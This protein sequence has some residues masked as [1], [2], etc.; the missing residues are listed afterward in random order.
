MEKIGRR[1]IFTTKADVTQEFLDKHVFYLRT[2]YDVSRD[3]YAH[4]ETDKILRKFL[5][6]S[7]GNFGCK[8]GF[9]I[10]ASNPSLNIEHFLTL[11]YVDEEKDALN[12]ICA[13]ILQQEH[14][15]EFDAFLDVSGFTR[16]SSRTELMMTFLVES[17]WQGIFGLGSRLIDGGYSAG[18]Q[19]VLSTLIN[20]LGVA[21]KN[22]KSFEE[23]KKLNQDLNRKNI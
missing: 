8:R 2:L 7:M 13:E 12:E 17:E 9:I 6:M 15:T 4:V 3:I 19:E 20:N 5:L 14:P 18:D 11:G 10:L 23:I 22:A 16:A 1:E 21:L